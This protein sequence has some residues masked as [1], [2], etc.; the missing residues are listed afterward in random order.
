MKWNDQ[1]EKSILLWIPP[2]ALFL[3]IHYLQKWMNQKTWLL[4]N[5]HILINKRIY[6]FIH[7]CYFHISIVRQNNGS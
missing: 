5:K 2:V 4:C 7:L 1:E 3:L 6:W